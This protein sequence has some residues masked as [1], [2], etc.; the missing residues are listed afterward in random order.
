MDRISIGTRERRDQRQRGQATVELAL[1]LPMVVLLIGLFVQVAV[2]V[3]DQTRLWQAAREAARAAVVDPDPRQISTAA[4]RSG[5]S[6]VSVAVSPQPAYRAQGAPLSVN[7]AFRPRAVFPMFDPILSGV[8]LHANA[9]MRI[10]Q[11]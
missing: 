5:L 11:P 6:P 8:E 9:T 10:E 3:S 4:E 1:C 2:V 7:L